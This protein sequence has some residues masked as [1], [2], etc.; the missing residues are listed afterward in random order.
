M[1]DIAKRFAR[2]TAN[3]TMTVLHDDG[4]YRHLRYTNPEHSWNHWFD[5]ITVPG[6]LIFQGDGDT[7]AFR[8][9]EDMFTFF[10]GGG[11]DRKPNLSYWAEKL[12]CRSEIMRYDQ[13]LLT[14]HVKQALEDKYGDEPQPD[15]LEDAIQSD[16]IDEFCG[17]ESI[18]RKVVDDFRWYAE[19]ADRYAFPLK[20]PDFEFSETWE[21]TCRDYHWWFVWACHAIVWGIAQYDANGRT[22]R[23]G[24][25]V[26]TGQRLAALAARSFHRVLPKTLQRSRRS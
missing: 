10:R 1:D 17:D 13:E 24:L 14:E 20:A 25:I 26:S 9:L 18:D 19:S 11:Y 16:V 7:F 12:T 3:H 15:G 22:A 5:L 6:G 4:L 21:W 23:A 2:D 8:R